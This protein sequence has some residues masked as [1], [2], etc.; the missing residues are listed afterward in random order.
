MRGVVAVDQVLE[1]S[2][3]LF[4]LLIHCVVDGEALITA[5]H[6]QLALNRRR[7]TSRHDFISMELANRLDLFFLFIVKRVRSFVAQKFGHIFA[8]PSP[9][10]LINDGVGD[11]MRCLMDKLCAIEGLSLAGR[12]A[13]AIFLP[14]E[15]LDLFLNLRVH[16][17]TRWIIIVA[18]NL[19]CGALVIKHHRLADLDVA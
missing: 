18:Q 3:A 15:T 1:R 11:R 12:G 17:V 16:E 2:V 8:S 13:V 10:S 19:K 4:P 6:L 14:R 5:A 7:V 9:N